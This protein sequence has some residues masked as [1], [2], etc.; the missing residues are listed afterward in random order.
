MMG[1][2]D[3]LADVVTWA[4]FAIIAAMAFTI[5][6]EAVMRMWDKNDE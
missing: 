5:A 1:A 4:A 3:T 2:I 6:A